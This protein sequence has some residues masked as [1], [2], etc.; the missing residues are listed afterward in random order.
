MADIIVGACD[1]YMM[2]L[3]TTPATMAALLT[4]LDVPANKVAHSSGGTVVS[5]EPDVLEVKNSYG[6][7]VEQAV[8][9]ENLKITFG[10]LKWDLNQVG[11]M[12]TATVTTATNI[13]TLEFGK[14]G[15]TGKLKKVGLLLKHKKKSGKF[16]T[17]MC[18]AQSSGG[19]QMEF[20]DK[21]MVIGAEFKAIQELTGAN[22]YLLQIKDD[23]TP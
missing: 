8:T 6:Q 19:F 1:I 12:S 7:I 5:Y 23:N 2:E 13:T 20:S 10:L 3:T 9:T 16:L 18:I 14:A 22:D 21:E 17:V 11:S 15:A 4:S